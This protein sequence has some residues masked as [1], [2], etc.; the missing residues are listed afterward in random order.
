MPTVATLHRTSLAAQIPAAISI[1]ES[2]HPPAFIDDDKSL[3]EAT[4]A[5]HNTYAGG[6][7]DGETHFAAGDIQETDETIVHQPR[8]IVGEDC[9]CLAVTDA[10]LRFSSPIVRLLQPFLKI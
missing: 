10:P 5:S 2:T 8:A 1:C 7:T 3:L 4:K 9:I 6:F